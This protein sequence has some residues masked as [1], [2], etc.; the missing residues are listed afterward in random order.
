M[1][2]YC[3]YQSP[4]GRL[5]LIGKNGVLEELLFPNE[6]QDKLIDSGFQH[7]EKIFEPVLKQLR[8]YFAGKRQHFSLK[9]SPNGT[10]FQHRVWQELC[11]IPYGQTTSYGEVAARLGNP[12]GGR[13]VGMANGKNP[14]P[15]IVPCHRVIGKD[16]SL[17]GFGGGLDI[18]R[19]LLELENQTG[20][21]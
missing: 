5:M 19:Q 21:L 15:I 12:K 13:A 2:D 11:N 14:I 17:T 18:K 9:L 8:E 10:E 1:K 4:I 3:Y 7:N 20:K 16:G 6:V